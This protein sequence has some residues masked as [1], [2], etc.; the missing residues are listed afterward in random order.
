[1]PYNSYEK[2]EL[3]KFVESYG[4]ARIDTN[5]V[6]YKKPI[7]SIEIDKNNKLWVMPSME[8]TE[9][10][11]DSFYID[12]FEK[13]IFINRTVLDFVKGGETY[14]LKGNRL[15]VISEDGKSLR[16]YDYE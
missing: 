4:F 14:K 11:K 13:G 3:S 5:K 8:R 1:V 6:Y 9:A 15:Y 2:S 16:V 7:N 12:I 10:N